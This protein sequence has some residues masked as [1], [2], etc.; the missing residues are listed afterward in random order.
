MKIFAVIELHELTELIAKATAKNDFIFVKSAQKKSEDLMAKLNS[1]VLL[2]KGSFA[3]ASNTKGI[4][5]LDSDNIEELESIINGYQQSLKSAISLGLG[6]ELR[7]AQIANVKSQQSNEPEFYSEEDE[8]ADLEA[9]DKKVLNEI[10]DK[11]TKNADEPVLAPDAATALQ[12]DKEY[13]DAQVQ[14]QLESMA[15]PQPEPQL[16]PQ[17]GEEPQAEVDP[18]DQMMAGVGQ[19]QAQAQQEPQ[20]KDELPAAGGTPLTETEIDPSKKEADTAKEEIGANDPRM[21]VAGLLATIKM[22]LPDVIALAS[23]D[24]EAF[25]LA[26]KM[27]DGALKLGKAIRTSEGREA[28]AKAKKKDRKKVKRFKSPIF[29]HLQ[30]PPATLVEKS[31][32]TKITE[33]PPDFCQGH[34]GTYAL[35]M[36][37]L[38][39][40]KLQLGMIR[41][42]RGG[43]DVNVHSFV[44]HPEN[45]GHLMDIN[46]TNDIDAMAN[47]W[48]NNEHIYNPKHGS[49]AEAEEHP[50]DSREEFINALKETGHPDPQIHY[51]A[52]VRHIKKKYP[53]LLGKSE[54][55]KMSR[56]QLKFPQ[57]GEPK[58]HE[59]DVRLVETPRQ[60]EIAARAAAQQYYP[61]KDYDYTPQHFDRE[62]NK[63]VSGPTEKRRS[64]RSMFRERHAK[65][66]SR[67]LGVKNLGVS[68]PTEGKSGKTVNMTVAGALRTR[69]EQSPAH[70]EHI[71]EY[72]KKVHAYNDAIKQWRAEGQ[73]M[74]LRGTT[75]EAIDAHQAKRPK[76]PAKF[77]KKPT[78][79]VPTTQLPYEEQV[80]RGRST[81][82]TVAHEASHAIFSKLRAKHGNQFVNKLQN[83]LLA[84]L[85]RE[86][87]GHVYDYA[88]RLGYKPRHGHFLEEMIALSRDLLTQPEKRKQFESNLG[89]KGREHLKIIGRA[90]NEMVQKAKAAT[91]DMQFTKKSELSKAVRLK[92]PVGTIKDGKLKVEDPA[93]GRKIWRGVRTGLVQAPDGSPLSVKVNNRISEDNTLG[94]DELKKAPAPYLSEA[95]EEGDFPEFSMR[96]VNPQYHEKIREYKLPNGLVHE[97]HHKIDPAA[98]NDYIHVLK[99]PKF[100]KPLAYMSVDKVGDDPD[101]NYQGG[102]RKVGMSMVNPKLKGKGLGKQLYMAALKHHGSLSS[103]TLVSPHAHKMWQSLGDTGSARVDLAEYSPDYEYDP[104]NA[105]WVGGEKHSRKDFPKVKLPAAKSR[106]TKQIQAKSK[107]R[108]RKAA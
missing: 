61:D 39:G 32:P 55:E 25:K 13:N 101:A 105:D 12:L 66:T 6:T 103:D 75:P 90:W 59:S 30:L 79:G 71:K 17:A 73:S 48:V 47:E 11:K 54:L 67:D 99:H 89:D 72:N 24:P 1:F 53:S 58:S 43:E 15:P 26:M 92:L 91:P 35:A 74:I 29:S 50:F 98:D 107:K 23:K 60:K 85:P 95:Y 69:H 83:H 8:K 104:H 76:P 81:D 56:P 82:A 44:Y 41:G 28:L 2:H 7:H 108:K 77:R 36:H 18:R 102:S 40:G 84:S 52:A 49:D 51:Q 65:R 16:Q 70:N 68:V 3:S 19:G 86:T 64:S 57:L 45:P 5:E 10:P 88:R 27:M 63:L 78:K 62:A 37:D 87:V 96:S 34:C 22:H 80:K 9:K 94:K 4:L 106:A 42:T 20:Q 33:R 100:R 21:K 97:V 31:E 38:S 14:I 93:T 46:G